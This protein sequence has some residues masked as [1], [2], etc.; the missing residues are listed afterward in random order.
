MNH[1]LN[2]FS[3]STPVRALLE[4]SHI[5]ITASSSILALVGIAFGALIPL[6]QWLNTT[7]TIYWICTAITVFIVVGFFARRLFFNG[8]SMQF[9]VRYFVFAMLWTFFP[10]LLCSSVFFLGDRSKDCICNNYGVVQLR[11][12]KFNN[13]V[14]IDD[15]GQIRTLLENTKLGTRSYPNFAHSA[16]VD[17]LLST[18]KANATSDSA[19]R[20]LERWQN[21]E[22][23]TATVLMR[24][25]AEF[26]SKPLAPSKF[27][28]EYYKRLMYQLKDDSIVVGTGT[29]ATIDA[30]L[31]NVQR[32]SQYQPIVDK[33]II[34]AAAKMLSL[35]LT[36][37]YSTINDLISVN[38]RAVSALDQDFIKFVR[39]IPFHEKLVSMIGYGHR[40]NDLV[41][42]EVRSQI[43]Y[44]R[45]TVPR[46]LVMSH[47]LLRRMGEGPWP[48][49]KPIEYFDEEWW[50]DNASWQMLGRE[51][52]GR[53]DNLAIR[54]NDFFDLG[55]P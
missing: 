46:S 23:E 35:R 27:S 17:R 12:V 34:R 40:S 9:I 55:P 20:F 14:K 52:S 10:I 24:M 8:H 7:K 42:F 6:V 22:D 50:L 18:L 37:L 39:T 53:L 2:N 30:L 33:V 47:E 11:V 3:R 16:D 51:T 19:A 45:F 43:S 13:I 54:I 26:S 32:G 29:K 31:A 41:H 21:Y 4:G 36:K 49:G 25:I 5:Y 48:V 38:D 1:S 28:E 44:S 15:I